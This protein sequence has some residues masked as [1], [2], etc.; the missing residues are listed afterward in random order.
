MIEIWTYRKN[1]KQADGQKYLPIDGWSD[2]WTDSQ[3]VRQT[4]S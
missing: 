1:D 4:K 3:A 2:K